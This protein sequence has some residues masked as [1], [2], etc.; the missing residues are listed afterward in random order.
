MPAAGTE[1]I[2]K[3]PRLRSNASALFEVVAS[4]C[5]GSQIAVYH[6]DTAEK[7][8]LAKGEPAFIVSFAQIPAESRASLNLDT[9]SAEALT[10]S[11]RCVRSKTPRAQQTLGRRTAAETYGVQLLKS[12]L[13]H[14]SRPEAEPVTVF[15]VPENLSSMFTASVFYI[16]KGNSS[17]GQE[18][19]MLPTMRYHFSGTRSVIIADLGELMAYMET[20]GASSK[21]PEDVYGFLHNVSGPVLDELVQAVPLSWG[22]VGAGEALVMPYGSVFTES[23]GEAAVGLRVPFLGQKCS[24]QACH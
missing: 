22:T 2:S 23:T 4:R 20:Q 8:P 5:P 1:P 7:L 12:V 11:H 21:S 17:C 16:E 14:S 24:M 10:L 19:Y 13:R 15:D 3:K 18:K 9:L 6:A